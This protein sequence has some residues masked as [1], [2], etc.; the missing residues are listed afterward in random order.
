MYGLTCWPGK[1]VAPEIW[2]WVRPQ[3]PSSAT[4]DFLLPVPEFAAGRGAQL[5]DT[6][7][8]Y[9]QSDSP[10]L[11]YGALRGLSRIALPLDSPVSA[12]VRARAGDA[13]IRAADHIIQVDPENINEYAAHLGQVQD[14][15]AHDLLWD[16]VNRRI[17]DEQ[18]LIALTWRKSHTDL[19]RLAQLPLQP[20]KGDPLDSKFASLPYALHNAY[21]EAAIPYLDTLLDRSPYTWVRTNCARELMLASRPEGFA[22]VADSIANTRL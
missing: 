1:Q 22:F 8:P 10:V 14:E 16:L 13:M 20:T 5:V 11:V 6:S 4:V 18:A 15:R 2:E 3:G 9:L 17:G 19:P 7:I 12:D 21:G